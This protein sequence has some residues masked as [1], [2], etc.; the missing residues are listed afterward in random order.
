M[1]RDSRTSEMIDTLLK[2]SVGAGALVTGVFIPNAMI[3]LEKPL[4]KY[5]DHLDAKARERE[6][7]RL[8][9]YMKYRGLLV[10]DYEFGLKISTKGQERLKQLDF[11]T[12]SIDEPRKWDHM[13]RIIIYD[14]PESKKVGRQSLTAKLR[15]LGFV[16][17]Q[18]SAWIHPFPCREVIEK[19]TSTYGI[20]K[21]VSYLETSHLDNESVLVNR[22]Q[23]RIPTVIFK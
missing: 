4:G 16:Q 14:I 9:R 11:E 8:V 3:A 12:M 15:E 10:G 18:K 22:F 7:M 5:F 17:L 20:E 13:W 1:A 6:T 2:F 23:K 19:I 21:Y